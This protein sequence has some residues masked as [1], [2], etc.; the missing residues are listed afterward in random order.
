[1]SRLGL[2]WLLGTLASVAGAD[3][4]KFVVPAGQRQLFLDDHGVGQLENVRRVMHRPRKLGAVIRPRYIEGQDASIQ[5]RSG[6]QWDVARGV[7]RLWLIS[8]DCYESRDGLHWTPTSKRPNIA[9]LNAVIDPD[10]PD[11]NRRYK[12]LVARGATRE[13]VVSPDGVTWTK[14]DVPPIPSQDESNLSYDRSRRLFIA[15][16][17]HSGPF[18]RTVWLST[19]EDFASWTKPELIFHP[20]KRDQELAKSVIANR[21]ADATLQKMFHNDPDVYNVQVYNMGVFRY[22]GLYVG[23]PAMFHSTGRVPNY[24]NTDGFHVIQLACSRDRRQWTRL[25]DRG[26]FIGP[27]PA[28]GG[29]FDLTQILPPS[30]P[31]VRGDELWFYYTGLKYRAS[32][33]YV[34]A[35]PKGKMLPKTGLDRAAGAICLAVL[36]RDGFVS[37]DAGTASGRVVSK[38]FVPPAGQLH[39]NADLGESGRLQVAMLAA[40]GRVIAHSQP[41]VGNQLRSVVHWVKPLANQPAE[42]AIRLRFTLNNGSLY[43]FWYDQPA[44]DSTGGAQSND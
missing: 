8:R 2:V 7:Y 10:D 5:T 37:L 24:P 18:G 31:I 44:V 20:D 15:T 21:L 22:E 26:A 9:V 25:G 33:R 30:A 4:S 1:M 3:S 16:V 41:I 19:S 29:A 32:F 39:V 35:Y 23:L 6:P 11:P 27:S 42:Q 12:G 43:S 13:P 38:P 34:G 36:R 40:D 14:L 17:K 28:A